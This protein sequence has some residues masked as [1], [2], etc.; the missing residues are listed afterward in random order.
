MSE[1]KYRD[2]QTWKINVTG[3]DL[4]TTPQL[5]E[6]TCAQ[7][8]DSQSPTGFPDAFSLLSSRTTKQD[9]NI[10]TFPN[11][12]TE[13]K[14]FESFQNWPICHSVQPFHLVMAVFFSMQTLLR[15][16]WCGLDWKSWMMGDDP[17]AVHA[18]LILN[19]P[20]LQSYTA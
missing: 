2:L 18:N 7:A 1:K 14:G 6:S 16:F 11:N 8:L 9:R 4:V 12:S 10:P 20:F 17:I 15:C 3:N 19:C 13:R 5:E